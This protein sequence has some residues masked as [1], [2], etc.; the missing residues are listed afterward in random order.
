MTG[1]Q[2]KSRISL[3]LCLFALVISTAFAAKDSTSTSVAG[4]LAVTKITIDPSVLMG[5]DTG[6][7][8][9]TVTN[10]GDKSVTINEA[11]L[12]AKELTVL[13]RSFP[14]PCLAAF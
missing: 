12:Y 2:I 5:D 11:N 3:L 14:I 8:T 10:T 9:L 1:I 6:I 13:I 4:Q 7:I